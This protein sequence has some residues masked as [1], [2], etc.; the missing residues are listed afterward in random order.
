MFKKILNH[1]WRQKSKYLQ[2]GTIV[3]VLVLILYPESSW[4]A[5]T[6]QLNFEDTMGKFV[7]ALLKYLSFFLFLV[8]SFCGMLMDNNFIVGSGMDEVLH[9]IWLVVRNLINVGFV[10]VLLGAAFMMVIKPG[11]EGGIDMKNQLPRFVLAMIL[12]NFS[13]FGCR[14]VLDA[15]SV[16]TS[17]VFA[18]PQS[19][20]PQ[21]SQC[22]VSLPDGNGGFKKIDNCVTLKGFEVNAKQSLKINNNGQTISTDDKTDA[23]G[24]KVYDVNWGSIFTL[25]LKEL[26]NSK[27]FNQNNAVMVMAL[28]LASI[29]NLPLVAQQINNSSALTINIIFSLVISLIVAIPLIV[30]FVVLIGRMVIL[31]LTIAFMPIAFLAWVVQGS[32]TGALFEGMPDV[33]QE[34]LNA[35]FLPVYMAV[36]LSIGFLMINAGEKIMPYAQVEGHDV[37]IVFKPNLAG[38]DDVRL[39]LWH[40][41]TAAIIWM[42]VSIASSKGPEFMKGAVDA[43]SDTSKRWGSWLAKAPI[44]YAPLIPVKTGDDKST[45]TQYSLSSLFQFPDLLM[46]KIDSGETT[47]AGKLAA[48][49]TGDKTMEVTL[50]RN[51]RSY[52]DSRFQGNTD[53]DVKFRDRAKE[54][55]NTWLK[56]PNAKPE[57]LQRQFKQFVTSDATLKNANLESKPEQVKNLLNH[58]V[59]K[60][61]LEKDDVQRLEDNGSIKAMAWK[62]FSSGDKNKQ[63]ET[64]SNAGEPSLSATVV[65]NLNRKFP[66]IRGQLSDDDL[67]KISKTKYAQVKVL[68]DEL[69]KDSPDEAEVKKHL[70][71]M[72]IVL[73]TNP[74]TLQPLDVENVITRIK[75]IK[76]AAGVSIVTFD[77][78]QEAKLKNPTN[79][80][81]AE[82]IDRI[83]KD[84]SKNDAVKKT[85]I[86]DELKNLA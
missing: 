18:I 5:S 62:D 38:M 23:D 70:E 40:I 79:K 7:S 81:I 37:S 3:L 16:L 41:A 36:P 50:P 61:I 13:W 29:Q 83:L 73:T 74:P 10:I 33:V 49:I 39:I 20:A 4:A 65:N 28:N 34:F 32:F 9:Q 24:N 58:F 66:A 31:W 43:I 42:S 64:A 27:F 78:G 76:D 14:V 15:S 30:L 26:P 77:T 57:D 85:A 48:L 11:G 72:G 59:T 84:S 46:S 75:D 51:V 1:F 22:S 6:G 19:I 86:E 60:G 35:A 25:Q 52:I 67:K 55:S 47:K 71:G 82:A 69:A 21:Y 80:N 56:N 45:P 63:T 17:T 53:D 54:F 8:L 68:N 12:V 44:K 2:F